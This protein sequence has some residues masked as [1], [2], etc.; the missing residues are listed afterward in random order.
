[1]NLNLNPHK[2]VNRNGQSE[3]QSV[4]YY[5]RLSQGHQAVF[6]QRGRFYS[7]GGP[8]LTKDQLPDWLN[9]DIAKLSPQAKKDCGLIKG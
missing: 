2:F 6:I 8:E 9:A 4:D 5:I 1:M 3:L 7:E